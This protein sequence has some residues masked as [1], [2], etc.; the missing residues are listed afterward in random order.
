MH[1]PSIQP[2]TLSAAPQNSQTVL[3]AVKNQLGTIPNLHATLAHSPAVLESYTTQAGILAKGLLEGRLREQI[4]LAVAGSNG[5]NYCASAHTLLGAKAGLDRQE[6]SCNLSGSSNDARTEVVLDFV[7]N[8]VASRG[9]ITAEDL[10]AVR[11]AGY[12]EGEIV[13][14]IAHVGMNIFTNYFNL[15][16]GTEIDFPLVTTRS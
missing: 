4:A 11:E 15:I 6:L 3:Q 5:C 1:L 10:A 12:S 9:Q 2:L 16:A 8:I 13:E 14:M 7:N